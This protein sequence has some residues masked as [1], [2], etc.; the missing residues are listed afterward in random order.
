MSTFWLRMSCRRCANLS[1]V[2]TFSM[3]SGLRRGVEVANVLIGIKVLGVEERKKDL[4]IG[5]RQV[6]ERFRGCIHARAGEV[7]IAIALGTI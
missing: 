1:V 5:D 2:S 7:L 3:S 4:S 6:A